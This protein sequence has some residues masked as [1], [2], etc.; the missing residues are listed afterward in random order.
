MRLVPD[1][2]EAQLLSLETPIEVSGHFDDFELGVAF[3]DLLGTI[4]RVLT[5]I[6]VVPIE[7]LVTGPVPADGDAACAAAWKR[8]S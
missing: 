3:E 5:G 2:K 7:R 8:G 4:V 6:V 1:A